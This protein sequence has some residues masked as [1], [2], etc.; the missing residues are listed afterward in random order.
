MSDNAMLAL[1]SA[2]L[3]VISTLITSSGFWLYLDKRRSKRTLD[4]KLLIGLAHDRIMTLG[5]RY[6]RRG[7]INHDE[8][9]NLR[10]FLFTPYKELGANGSAEKLMLEIEKLPIRHVSFDGLPTQK[11]DKDVS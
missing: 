2:L 1:I 5:T 4:R 8:Y 11:G 7:Y 3:G 9:E 10:D 6:L